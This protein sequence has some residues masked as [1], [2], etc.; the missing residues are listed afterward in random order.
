MPSLE[1]RTRE[2]FMASSRRYL[3]VTGDELGAVARLLRQLFV[4]LGGA[5][6]EERVEFTLDDVHTHCLLYTSPSPR[7]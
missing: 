4:L 1:Y 6:G 3:Q 7:D 2:R 5:R